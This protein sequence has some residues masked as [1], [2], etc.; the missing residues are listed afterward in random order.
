MAFRKGMG[1]SSRGG[2]SKRRRSRGF[3]RTAVVLYAAAWL[4]SVILFWASAGGGNANGAWE[5]LYPAIVFLSVL[6]A[7]S[8]AASFL[9]GRS[10]ETI[11]VK[12]GAPVV[13]AVLNGVVQLVTTVSAAETGLLSINLS[14]VLFGLVAGFAGLAMG[15]LYEKSGR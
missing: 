6:P 1:M 11:A 13:F 8:L 4:F 5:M 7:A 2:T 12:V 14:F 10:D 3:L 9:F 15:V